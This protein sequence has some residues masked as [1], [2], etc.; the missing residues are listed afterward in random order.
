MGMA[1]DAAE[2]EAPPEHESVHLGGLL[3]VTP[4]DMERGILH[5]M[6]ALLGVHTVHDASVA[7]VVRESVNWT[8]ID[9]V[10]IALEPTDP[11]L[12]MALNAV[13][14]QGRI[15]T[16]LLSDFGPPAKLGIDAW[17]R[18]PLRLDSLREALT[19]RGS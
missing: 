3:V 4:H 10:L 13:R 15:Y 1:A 12:A 17:T 16:V 2:P 11:E 6:L 19:V 7:D 18:K 8:G 14:R 5:D 9:S